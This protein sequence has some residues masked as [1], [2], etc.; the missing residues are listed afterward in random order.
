MF[1]VVMALFLRETY[2]MYGTSKFG[3]F[4]ALLRDVFGVGVMIIFRLVSGLQFEKGLHVVYFVL[5][6]FFVYY[7]VTECVSKSMTAIQANSAILSFPHVI[8]LDVM[9]SRCL[10]SFFTNIQSS[11]VVVILAILYG[12]EFDIVNFGLFLYCVICSLLLGFSAGI[13]IAALAVFYPIVER[14]WPIISRIG[15]WVS[16]IFFTLDKFPAKYA[17][18]LSYN[19]ILQIIEGLRSSLSHGVELVPVLNHNYINSLIL[20]FFTLGLLLQ[21]LSRERLNE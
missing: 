5:C 12:I 6:G 4:W 1:T 10:F 14:I 7:I 15:F 8:P 20:I 17:E 11:V 13:F 16:G 2:T 21:K 9:I 18:P 3:Y 19:P